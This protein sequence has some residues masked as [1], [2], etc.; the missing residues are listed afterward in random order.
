MNFVNKIKTITFM[1]IK[2][3]LFYQIDILTPIKQYYNLSKL[4]IIKKQRTNKY[5]LVCIYLTNFTTAN[6]T[7]LVTKN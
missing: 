3:I 5:Q 7:P 4:I 2:H 6:K 1:I